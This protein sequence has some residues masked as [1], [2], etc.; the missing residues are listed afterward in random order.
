MRVVCFGWLNIDNSINT[1][2][3]GD[4]ITYSCSQSN[5]QSEYDIIMIKTILLSENYN[6]KV[7]FPDWDE[8]FHN[9]KMN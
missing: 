7:Y 9:E 6:K 8:V 2:S 4:V 1:H 3:I 5:I